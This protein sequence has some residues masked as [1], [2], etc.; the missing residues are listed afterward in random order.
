M[1]SRFLPCPK[2]VLAPPRLRLGLVVL[3]LGLVGWH[4]VLADE[5]TSLKELPKDIER[6]EL[7]EIMQGYSR[8]LGVRCQHCHVGEDD[9][10]S[11]DFDFVSEDNPNKDVARLM[12]RMT[13]QINETFLAKS[14]RAGSLQVTCGTCHRGQPRPISL[15][16]DLAE[17]LAAEGSKAA[18]QRYR[19]L[20]QEW[21]G[22]ATF[23]FGVLT[24]RRLASQLASAKKY[25]DA[26]VFL[27]LNLEHYPDSVDSLL[28]LASL[29]QKTDDTKGAKA[30]YQ[31]ILALDPENTSAKRRLKR[32]EGQP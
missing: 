17:T 14:G 25:T 6:R 19:V 26:I 8:S 29:Y 10:Y 7:M 21:Y 18:V 5:F 32:L 31:R 4:P 9:L 30:T 2:A 16:Q 22:R 3:C 12:I 28:Q 27:E 23:D 11:P 24:L 1:E 13:R 20:R 15:E